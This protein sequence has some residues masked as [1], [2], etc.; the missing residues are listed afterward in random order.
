VYLHHGSAAGEFTLSSDVVVPTYAQRPT[1]EPIVRRLRRDELAHFVRDRSTI[2][3][4]MVFPSQRVDKKMTINGA[5]GLN[6]QISD[7]MDLTLEC[8][9]RHYLGGRSPLSETLRRY[10][11]FFALFEDFDGYTA[12]FLLQDLVTSNT[13]RV[14]FFMPFDDFHAPA[15]PQDLEAY[16]AYL[17]SSVEF[18]SAR[19]CRI[20]D[21][22]GRS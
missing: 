20:D 13:A 5:R 10:A 11:D 9:R 21:L 12:F 4:F 22:W 15:L 14:K 7:R 6:R 1:V 19:N 17:R 8:I 18:I 2:G 3:A 16:R